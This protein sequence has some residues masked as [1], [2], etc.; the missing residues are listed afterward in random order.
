MVAGQVI[1]KQTTAL[2][3]RPLVASAR[4]TPVTYKP[5][6]SSRHGGLFLLGIVIERGKSGPLVLNVG[7]ASGAAR[8]T[9]EADWR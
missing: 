7:M 9:R 6:V 8:G 2:F 3:C 4:S 1:K 5:E